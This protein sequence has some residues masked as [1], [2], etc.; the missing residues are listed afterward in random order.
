[1]HS[2]YSN[3]FERCKPLSENVRKNAEYPRWKEIRITFT[4][5]FYKANYFITSPRRCIFLSISR[6]R[7]IRDCRKHVGPR[8]L[9]C[10]FYAAYGFYL[11]NDEFKLQRSRSLICLYFPQSS[12]IFLASQVRFQDEETINNV[13]AIAQNFLFQSAW[14]ARTSS[15]RCNDP[16]AKPRSLECALLITSRDSR[17]CRISW[18]L[19]ERSIAATALGLSNCISAIKCNKVS[20][21]ILQGPW[22][23]QRYRYSHWSTSREGNLF[24]NVASPR[25]FKAR[26]KIAP[27]MASSGSASAAHRSANA[28]RDQ[29]RVIMHIDIF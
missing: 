8:I 22:S 5:L 2:V 25:A 12:L 24:F 10:S 11:R 28:P 29:R 3:T 13:T 14:R 19:R 1:V 27:P 20:G 18:I 9:R 16:G 6:R 26:L 17:W 15:S 21:M 4:K 7:Y 23:L